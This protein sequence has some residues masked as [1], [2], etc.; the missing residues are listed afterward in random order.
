MKNQPIE[1]FIVLNRGC[2]N[3]MAIIC[4]IDN[5]VSF[6]SENALLAFL[7]QPHNHCAQF[8]SIMESDWEKNLTASYLIKALI[9]MPAKFSGKPTL[10][11]LFEELWVELNHRKDAAV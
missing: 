11:S 7:C 3:D 4:D 8:R 2:G 9:Q 1:R 5:C 6:V 10:Y